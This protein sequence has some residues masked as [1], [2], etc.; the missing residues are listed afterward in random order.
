MG[1]CK[2][3][4]LASFL[5]DFLGSDFE[6]RCVVVESTKS[7]KVEQVSNHINPCLNCN[8]SI[9]NLNLD[10]KFNFHILQTL[11]LN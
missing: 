3:S 9:F 1:A 7:E 6:P 5:A 11:K 2:F 10:K 8:N 4:Y